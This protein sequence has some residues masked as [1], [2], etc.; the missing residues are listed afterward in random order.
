MANKKVTIW[1][2]VR[3]GEQWRYC[4]PVV[5]A[6]NK[7]KPD[8]VHVNGHE[9]RHPEGTYML[10]FLEGKKQVWAKC[11]PT[12]TTAFRR[13]KWG[14]PIWNLGCSTTRT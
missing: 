7:I 1:K 6:N 9:E 2:R 4:R 13:R 5:G 10:H 3:V 11:G 8:Y 12:P 14:L